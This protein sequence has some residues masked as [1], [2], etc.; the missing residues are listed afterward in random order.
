M[1]SEL[2]IA[3]IAITLAAFASNGAAEESIALDGY[4]CAQFLSDTTQPA[5]GNK[6]LK[7]LMMISWATGYAAAFQQKLP[8]ADAAAIVLMAGTLGDACR[9]QPMEKAVKAIT[10]Q[11][12][13][14]A[15]REPS[16]EVRPAPSAGAAPEQ[17]FATYAS[18][19]MDG[20]DY[21]IRRGIAQDQ[22]ESLCKNETRCKAYSYDLWKGSCYLKDSLNP[23]RLDPRSVTSALKSEQVSRDQ[24]D[25]VIEKRRQKAFPNA[26]YTH[27]S[28]PNYGECSKR[29]LKDDRCEGFNFYQSRRQ[30]SLIEKP[31]EYSDDRS[32]DLGI[33]MQIPK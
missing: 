1:R 8:R 20:G 14:F 29:C 21:D 18:R 10:N 19:D 32:A 2:R 22:C 15:N 24:R 13:E 12:N 4:T 6:V 9:K 3:S 27:I 30:C 17:F 5:D 33:K 31:K 26:P 16:P 23:M 25:P 28:L 11:I 7:T